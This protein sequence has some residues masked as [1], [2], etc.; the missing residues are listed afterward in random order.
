MKIISKE[1]QELKIYENNPKSH[2]QEQINLIKKSIKKFGFLV[3]ILVDSEKNI[4]CGHGRLEAAKQLEMQKVPVI[5]IK[6]L[7]QSQ[8]NAFRIADNKLSESSWNDDFLRQ[9]IEKLQED[10]FDI[11]FC[12]FSNEE[13]EELLEANEDIDIFESGEKEE[14]LPEMAKEKRVKKEDLWILGNHKLLCG[15][16]TKEESIQ[17]LLGQEK[18]DSLITDPPYGIENVKKRNRMLKFRKV[19][20]HRKIENDNLNI[21]IE[22]FES[23]F[24]FPFEYLSFYNTIYIFIVPKSLNLLYQAFINLKGYFSTYLIWLK[25]HFVLSLANYKGKYEIILYGWKGRHKFYGGNARH[26]ILE[27]DKP[28]MSKLHPTMKPILLLKRLIQDG[29]K[30]NQIVFD[31]FGGS[32]STLIA[33]EETNR[34]CRM[35]EIDENYCDI[36]LERWENLTGKKAIKEI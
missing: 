13:I 33:C 16:C 19:I 21:T 10:N 11:N 17:K 7:T 23:F 26:N 8:I 3:P 18:I 34:K 25:N 2:P 12:G 9:E 6:N 29:T 4:V 36:I 22:I 15:D 35:I 5:E 14:N 24:K 20:K 30:Q 32:G 31:G 1:I 27:F 28:Q